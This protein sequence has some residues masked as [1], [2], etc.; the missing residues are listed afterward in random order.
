MTHGRATVH[1]DD[2]ATLASQKIDEQLEEGVQ[3]E[4]LVDI[5]ERIDPEGDAQ[6]GQ[7][8]PGRDAEDG[9]HDE[10][11]DDMALEKRFAVVLGLEEDRAVVVSLGCGGIGGWSYTTVRIHAM[12]ADTPASMRTILPKP[13]PEPDGS[14]CCP[15]AMVRMLC[16][17]AL[18]MA[19]L[20]A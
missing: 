10:D 9:H 17:A 14:F 2:Q 12:S 20:L 16:S 18:M 7:G 4:S 6:G 3:C 13:E 5:P 19:A 11:A 15:P 8:G 1:H